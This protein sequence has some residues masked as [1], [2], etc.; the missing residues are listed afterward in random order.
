MT[1]RLPSQ[2][3]I[4][5]GDVT[6]VSADAVAVSRGVSFNRTTHRF[7]AL[8]KLAQGV[9]F[10][11]EYERAKAASSG[12][13]TFWVTLGESAAPQ[14]VLF[15]MVDQKDGAYGAVRGA[16]TEAVYHLLPVN[17]LPFRE[18]VGVGNSPSFTEGPGAGNRPLLIALIAFR[19]HQGGDR[20]DR[21]RS[22][23]TQV[24]A[25]Y[26]TL[27]EL[28]ARNGDQPVADVVF[29]LDDAAKYEIF[30]DARRREMKRL[31]LVPQPI[32]PEWMPL[33]EAVKNEECV[34]FVGA[35]LSLNARMPS[36]R[37]L[38]ETMAKE[39]GIDE[40]LSPDVDTYLDV[41]QAYR[42][43]KKPLAGLISAY[44]GDGQKGVR[45]SIAHYLL[46][47][48]PIRFIVTTNYDRLLETTLES[49]RRFPIRIVDND[50]IGRTGYRD[51][52]YVV[53]FHGDAEEGDVV[54][55]RDDYDA[56]FQ[57]RPAMASL[58]EGLLLNQT[59]FFVGYSL[60]D[61]NY[62]QIYSKIDL[63]LR[64]SKRP[65]FA[66]TFDQTKAHVAAQYRRKQ[67]RLIELG[68]EQ[69]PDGENSRR[70]L[71]FL[72]RLAEEVTGR[73][74][75]FLAPDAEPDRVPNKGSKA[76]AVRLMADSLRQVGYNLAAAVDTGL[77]P[78]EVPVAAQ[79]LRFLCEHGW[80]PPR[81]QT[82]AKL[83]LK[84]ADLLPPGDDCNRERRQYTMSALRYADDTGAANLIRERLGQ[85]P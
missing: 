47:S 56:F 66:T 78:H 53:K 7:A 5:Q 9:D 20:N 4:V 35:G 33:V 8:S 31:G 37:N 46:M 63:M 83:W 52:L 59:F 58:L 40:E 84:L 50:H 64:S 49:L 38:V 72:D 19:M 71:A 1:N 2:V 67:M 43:A 26:E 28:A 73:S 24:Q 77:D 69:A 51:G 85:M 36:Y 16:I 25:A 68:M 79:T 12:D 14:G 55:S 75:L 32:D 44:F 41:A 11:S 74:R 21:L 23:R 17:S 15:V 10:V 65:A 6:N 13:R 42:D 27:A 48:L 54:V 3:F 18:G 30:L 80:R 57:E 60:R 22:A 76:A 70:L 81:S 62:R 29:I 45:P 61:P 34:L 39:I 82:I